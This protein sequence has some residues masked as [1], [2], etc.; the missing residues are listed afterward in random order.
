[1]QQ[2]SIWVGID[3]GTQAHQVCVMDSSQRVVAELS[4]PH[5][6]EAIAKFVDDLVGMA[7]G[8]PGIVAVAIETP[9]GA[10]VETLI[11]R[12]IAVFSIN[13]KQLDRFRDRHTVA[14]AKDD[15]RDAFVLSDSLR[16]DGPKFRRIRLA[17][18]DIV[19]IREL[20]RVHE[21][22]SQEVNAL[23]NRLQDQLR[24]YY[25]QVLELGS[26]HDEPW[27][28]D[29]LQAVPTPASAIH[30]TRAKVAAILAR[31]RIRR[32]DANA[33][34]GTL[35]KAPL[36]VAP[37][38]VEA[39]VEHITLL[40]PRLRLAHEQRR[41]CQR[42]MEQLLDQLG[43]PA[44]EDEKREHRDAEI[45]RSLPGVGTLVGATMLAEAT[46]P[47]E[48]RDYRSLRALC[49][50]APVTRQSGK[51][52]TVMMRRACNARLRQAVFHWARISISHDPRATEHYA[53][54][55]AKGHS[56]G[57]ALR[58][59][60][61]RLLQMLIAMLNQRELYDACRRQ[62]AGQPKTPELQPAGA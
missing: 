37:G 34:L 59:V 62:S 21:D 14:G 16:T 36:H 44:S 10:I 28:W 43:E 2:F 15:R 35:R 19:Q 13:P 54:L 20:V 7:K 51:S 5:T 26:V 38:V 23:G 18:P 61:D 47:L 22:L 55:R 45:L 48:E 57:R 31:S 40:L 17:D 46:Q 27:I 29:V 58:G 39:S 1:M 12:G 49:G 60:A 33:V 3:W 41:H 56:F 30:I 6:G 24:R 9:R 4:V 53:R 11:D 25:P 8:E 32:L 42:R 50:V 52:S